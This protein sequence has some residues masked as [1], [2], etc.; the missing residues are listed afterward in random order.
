M[1]YIQLGKNYEITVAFILRKYELDK[2][3]KHI[4]SHLSIPKR[5]DCRVIMWK[6]EIMKELEN[7][8]T[9]SF[10]LKGPAMKGNA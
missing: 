2:M 4:V 9:T 6:G 1:G 3:G 8:G 10:G 5:G 7:V